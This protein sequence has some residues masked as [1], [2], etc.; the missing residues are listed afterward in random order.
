MVPFAV[1]GSAVSRYMPGSRPAKLAERPALPSAAAEPAVAAAA[2]ASFS[3][4]EP[5]ADAT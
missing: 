5:A 3:T 4:K 2:F 1:A